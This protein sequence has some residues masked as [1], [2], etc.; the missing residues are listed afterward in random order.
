MWPSDVPSDIDVDKESYEQLGARWT[1]LVDLHGEFQGLTIIYGVL[2]FLV[3]GFIMGGS[4][5]GT[6]NSESG[7]V[8]AA[9]LFIVLLTISGYSLVWFAWTRRRLK[10]VEALMDKKLE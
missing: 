2:A 4:F 3:P 1:L 8:V 5:F 7:F 6:E 10:R 9:M